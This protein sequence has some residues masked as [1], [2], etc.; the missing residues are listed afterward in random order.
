MF[1]KCTVTDDGLH[2]LKHVI[3]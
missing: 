2:K 3:R 1:S